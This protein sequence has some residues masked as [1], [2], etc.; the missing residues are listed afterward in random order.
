V[1]LFDGDLGLANADVLLGLHPEA[2]L[3]DVVVGRRRLA[4][5]VVRAPGGLDLAPGGSGLA[6]LLHLDHW[7][8]ARL[9]SELAD[10][11]RNYDL[12]L[13]D[14]AAGLGDDVVEFLSCAEEVLVVTTPEP[15]ALTDAYAL[16]K[17]AH[18][19]PGDPRF[20]LIVNQSRGERDG[21]EAGLRLQQ[22]AR[23]FLDVPLVLRGIIPFCEDVPRS[24][25]AQRPVLMA[26]PRGPFSQA[27][28]SVAADLA[29]LP[30]PPTSG[31]LS[32][33]IRTW[34]R[35]LSS[36]VAP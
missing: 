8:R 24:V 19:G 17:V 14:M 2:T 30:E 32:S 21:Q 29:G 27:V 25:R 7:G 4:E 33:V 11:E 18:R 16:V 13:I 36:P 23:T 3:R 1:L 12:V 6:E 10:V 5:V 26:Y 22:V 35:R 34:F 15:T 20:S 31:G 9:L 28:Q